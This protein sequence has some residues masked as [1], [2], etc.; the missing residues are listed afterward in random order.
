MCSVAQ[1]CTVPEGHRVSLTPVSCTS[2]SH[3]VFGGHLRRSRTTSQGNIGGHLNSPGPGFPSCLCIA[4][5]SLPICGC[6][7]DLSL[8]RHRGEKLLVGTAGEPE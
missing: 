4:N 7:D 6:Q 2:S 3:L 8:T 5:F 1:G